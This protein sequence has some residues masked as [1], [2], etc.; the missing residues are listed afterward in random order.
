[1]S[2]KGTTR[3]DEYLTKYGIGFPVGNLIGQIVAPVM[4]VEN[5]SDYLFVDGDDAIEQMN[6]EHEGTPSSEVDFEL[7][8][9]YSFRSTRKALNTVVK[10]KEA[11]NAKKPV[12]L[13]KRETRKLT[14]RLRLKHEQRVATV[15][16]NPALVT[17]TVDIDATA[18]RRWDET[19]PTLETDIITALSTIYDEVGVVANTIIMPYQAALYAA[20]LDFIK[21]TLQYQHGMSVITS[22]FQRQ[23]M[24]TVGLPPIIKGLNV[25][26]SNGRINRANKGETRDVQ[27]IWGADCLIGYIPPTLGVDMMMGIGTCEFEGFRVTKERILDPRGT[28]ILTEWDYDVI[29]CN[30]GCWYLMQ[31]VIA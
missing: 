15:M 12:M 21:D 4:G 18:N 26:I 14:H 19:T 10:D 13:E 27:N 30:L 22:E 6:D 2:T 20:N 11:K 7:G 28:K 9:P 25:V 1:M 16:T 17:Q 8:T 23:V 31:N 29:Q 3:Y 5:F 24:K